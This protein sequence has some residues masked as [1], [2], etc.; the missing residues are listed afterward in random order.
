[1][2]NARGIF[3]LFGACLA[4]FALFFL[5]IAFLFFAPWPVYAAVAVFL[6]IGV[7]FVIYGLTAKHIEV[8]TVVNGRYEHLSS[9]EKEEKVE[10]E[11][12]YDPNSLSTQQK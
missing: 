11:T 8:E 12:G 4:V 6:V 10:P 9:E 1:M 7:V 3:V 5:L 2:D